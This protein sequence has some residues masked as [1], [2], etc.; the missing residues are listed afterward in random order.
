MILFRPCDTSSLAGISECVPLSLKEFGTCELVNE[1]TADQVTSSQRVHANKSS[2]TQGTYSPIVHVNEFTV[3]QIIV[4]R[5][6]HGKKS[7]GPQ[8]TS[9]TVFGHKS[10]ALQGTSFRRVNVNESTSHE[11]S[12]TLFI[13][14]YFFQ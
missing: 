8:V 14:K 4:S 5:K 7:L 6:L 3:D 13:F 12:S 10:T 11:V 1:S 2:A 9:S